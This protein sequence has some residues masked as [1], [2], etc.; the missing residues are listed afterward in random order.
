MTRYKHVFVVVWIVGLAM[1]ATSAHAGFS[2]VKP[3]PLP[4]PSAAVGASPLS[5]SM[6]LIATRF[7]GEPTGPIATRYGFGRGVPLADALKQIAPIGWHA[8]VKEGMLPSFDR[9]RKVDWRGGRPWTTVLD[10]LANDQGFSV[11]ID[12][13]RQMLLIGQR[14]PVPTF[15]P[16]STPAAV[17]AA[18]PPKPIAP[19]LPPAPT[20]NWTIKQGYSIQQQLQEMAK[21]ARWNVVWNYPKDIIAGSDWTSHDDFPTAAEKIISILSSNGALIHY[22]TYTGNN[23]FVVYGPGASTP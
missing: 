21:K 18:T 11:E 17:A 8:R 2:V 19:P 22:Q 20:W 6:G 7:I 10:I 5:S 12:W 1:V 16:V 4:P 14:L 13:A 15:S 23:T 9:Q 3:S